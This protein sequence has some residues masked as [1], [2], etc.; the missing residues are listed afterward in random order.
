VYTR[1]LSSTEISALANGQPVSAPTYTLNTALN[2]DNELFVQS[3]VLDVSASNCSSASC[4][5][6]TAGDWNN[7]AGLDAFLRRTGTVTLDG[8]DQLINGTT[9]FYNLP[10]QEATND[11][12]DA[13]LTFEASKTQTIGGT[14]N[15]DGLDANDELAVRSSTAST[16]FTLDVT[17]ADQCTT[18]MDVKDSAASTN[19]IYAQDSTNSGGNDDGGAS[20]HWIFSACPSVRNRLLMLG[21]N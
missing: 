5:V 19:D 6:N 17:A 10:K 21:I 13:T 3:G 12:D 1:A 11:T 15:L 18:R 8:V 2:N 20:P 4:S 7:Y 16:Q 14:L 9:S